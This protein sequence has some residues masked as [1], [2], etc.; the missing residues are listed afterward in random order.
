VVGSEIRERPAFLQ[1]L[2]GDRDRAFQEFYQFAW[3]FLHT[4][5]PNAFRSFLPDDRKALVSDIIFHCV[6]D[7]FRVLRTY[8]GGSFAGWLLS[9]ARHRALDQLRALARRRE[10]P[11]PSDN[12]DEDKP[13]AELPSRQLPQDRQREWTRYLEIT[14]RCISMMSAKC[15]IL[16][17]SAAE[18]LRP[19]EIQ[20]LLGLGPG[21]NKA[22]ADDLRYCRER[23]KKLFLAEGI[24][25]RELVS[26]GERSG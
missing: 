20:R 22:V 24:D 23:L 15:Q 8:R 2:D 25:W 12:P 26:S 4:F 13:Q 5:P 21:S 1:N 19:Q 3:R 7:D 6:K 10:D 17:W 14:R 11:L 16:L 18:E 9:V